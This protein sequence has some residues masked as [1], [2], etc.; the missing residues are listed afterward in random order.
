M[1]LLKADDAGRA[2]LLV[3]GA[4]APDR[5]G[6]PSLPAGA[7]WAV[8]LVR[9][10]DEL[11]GSVHVALAR[12]AVVD[13][14]AAAR[15]LASA[16]A[17]VV[18]VTREGDVFAAGVAHGG[19]AKAPSLL[20]VQA[21][22]DE[23]R[24][25]LSEAT[26]RCERVR[27][28]LTS[29]AEAMAAAQ[30]RVESALTRL[31]ESDARMAA[32]AEQLGH[33][34]SAAR[35]ASGEA[36]RLAASIASATAARDA[37]QV[38]L[39]ELTVRLSAAQE[40]PDE[41]EPSSD[42]RDRLAAA[43]VL[44]RQSEVEARLAVRTGEER[45]QALAGR[46]EQLERAAAAE[47]AARVRNAERREA[48]ARAAIVAAAVHSGAVAT[49]ARLE[50]SLAV[51]S[52][53]R[54]DAE[55]AR[56]VREGE[57]LALRGRTRELQTEL[58]AL[59]SSVHRDEMARAEQRLRIEQLEAK[60][61]EDFGIDAETLVAEYGPD[62]EVPP[63]PYAPGDEVDPEAP[64]P[65]PYPYVRSEQE[66]RL[67]SAERSLALLG[68]V[69]PLALEEFS[70]LEERHRFLNEQLDDL[71]RSRA[72]LLSIITDVD[73]RVKQV[74]AEAY[75]DVERE[76]ERIFARLFPGG[77]GRLLLTDPDDLLTTGIEVEARPPGKKVKR[78]S[79]LSGG[80]RSLTAV[81]F[82]VALFKARP[83][84]FYI[85]D[86]VEA[87]LDDVNLQ[88]LLTVMEEL[89]ENSQLLVITHQKRTM[90]IADA[91]YGVSMRGDGVTTV[92]GQRLRDS[93][94][95]GDL[96]AGPETIALSDAPVPA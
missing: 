78:L 74:F 42:E 86:E 60:A 50:V 10:P 81:A 67:R 82:L 20:E 23:A 2:S 63:S 58:E 88:R 96:D 6:W 38:T 8:D 54:D 45:A 77:E 32:V 40:L 92:I 48:R 46:A 24:G 22:V 68:K 31:H 65:Q 72:E 90:E 26:H 94:E 55:Q 87:A 84:P 73:E 7:R 30:S 93:H 51:A 18:A 36:D 75:A 66:K 61:M 34:G 21:A 29:A 37:D 47:R 3:A 9:A 11:S 44:A 89:R 49:L 17:D 59:V 79:L 39:D 12:V 33:L 1:T 13:G 80:E 16:H 56:R 41:G 76:F 64:E 19:S 35:A 83:S 52:A 53:E 85:M 91:L 14:L 69:N 71:K 5:S 70:A 4:L 62:V 28:E 95:P 27:F 25:R 43:A 57:L 15:E